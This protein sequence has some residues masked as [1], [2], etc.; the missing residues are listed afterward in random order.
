M[1]NRQFKFKSCSSFFCFVVLA[2]FE[3]SRI[4]PFTRI[5]PKNKCQTIWA[6]PQHN[7]HFVFITEKRRRRR[8]RRMRMSTFPCSF[9]SSYPS[10]SSSSSS[11]SALAS[12]G[13]RVIRSKERPKGVVVVQNHRSSRYE[14][15]LSR[16]SSY[17]SFCF[18]LYGRG[19]RT[20]V[21]RAQRND[22][23]DEEEVE[24]EQQQQQQQQKNVIFQDML[25]GRV[26][27][28][29]KMLKGPSSGIGSV[30]DIAQ[31]RSKWD[32]PWGG[33]TV[34]GGILGWLTSFVL[35]AAV[36]VPLFVSQAL[37]L[38][39]SQF[40]VEQQA[41]YLLLV[42]VAETV[43]SLGIVYACVA[44]YKDE[45]FSNPENDWFR[46]D[47]SHPL[48]TSKNGWLVY[49]I[50][51]YLLTFVV[52]ALTG[53]AIESTQEVVQS[54]QDSQIAN[55]PSST[56]DAISSASA[57]ATTAKVQEAGTIDGVLPL[58]KSED[59]VAVGSL[60]AVTSVFAPLLEET[61]FRGFLL[62]SLTKWLPAPGAVVFSS[63]IFGLA[64]LAPRDFPELVAL[65]CVLGFSYVRTRNLLVPM[66]IH[67]CWN[68]GVLVLVLVAIHLGVAE[69]LGIPGF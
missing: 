25:E 14:E 9:S 47:F 4:E 64:H 34:F 35:T 55:D 39:R 15:P 48:D 63:F 41:Q 19:R 32:V 40:D 52:V 50:S 44:K 3:A 12:S 11:I 28:G 42:Q 60:L 31:Y 46:I 23:D 51:G 2:V 37:G 62:A 57:S 53:F 6:S 43:I 21:S 65:G 38:D 29:S 66:F 69:E 1:K 67:S 58:I 8:R 24:K 36:L 7:T 5:G 17:Q 68:S 49:G 16:S 20:D 27:G 45:M 61:V 30:L 56:I 26:R 33:W 54:I 10:S 18:Q 59:P 13:K 22:G